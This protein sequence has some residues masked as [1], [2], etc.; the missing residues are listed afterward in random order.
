MLF[1]AVIAFSPIRRLDLYN[2]FRC[3]RQYG[4]SD[5]TTFQV[6]ILVIIFSGI[7]GLYQGIIITQLATN[8]LTIGV[9]ARLI[10]MFITAYLMVH[11]DLLRVLVERLFFLSGC[12]LNVLLVFTKG[13]SLLRNELN[14]VILPN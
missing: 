9:I 7:R 11:F 3:N 4:R 12:S 14:P 5:F 6:I 2:N 8:W 13:D 10:A 1:S